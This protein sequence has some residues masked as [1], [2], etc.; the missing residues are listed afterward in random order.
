MNVLQLPACAFGAHRPRRKHVWRHE[1]VYRSVCCG[2]GKPMAR[3]F[4]RW[5]VKPGPTEPVEGA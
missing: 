1:G 3:G 4:G 2:C 5:V